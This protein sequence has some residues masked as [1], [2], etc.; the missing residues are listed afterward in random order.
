MP[1]SNLINKKLSL[2]RIKDNKT[3]K[4]DLFGCPIRCPQDRMAV[5]DNN[6]FVKDFHRLKPQLIAVQIDPMPFMYKARV[7]AQNMLP[8]FKNDL[9]KDKFGI[10]ANQEIEKMTQDDDGQPL[11][12]KVHSV[13][14]PMTWREAQIDIMRLWLVA[15][16]K[17]KEDLTRANEIFQKP[18]FIDNQEYLSTANQLILDL[19][20]Q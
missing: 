15:G 11:S 9:T 6:Q 14:F 1:T 7:F 12:Q 19:A 8:T 13:Y 3:C 2:E 18:D 16:C 10:F 5:D 4:L 20:N 17:T